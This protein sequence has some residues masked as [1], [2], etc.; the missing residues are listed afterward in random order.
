MQDVIAH[1]S[2]AAEL[3][4]SAVEELQAVEAISGRDEWLDSMYGNLQIMWTAFATAADGLANPHEHDH[5][6]EVVEN[7]R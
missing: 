3:M 7:A 1:L 2:R 6:H 4:N 5:V